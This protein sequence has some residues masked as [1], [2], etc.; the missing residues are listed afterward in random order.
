MKFTKGP[1][2]ID[3]NDSYSIKCSG[4][5]SY[6]LV[7][8]YRAL[9]FVSK[10]SPAKELEANAKLIAASPEMFELLDC[11]EEDIRDGTFDKNNNRESYL[12]SIN[13][14]ITKIE[15]DQS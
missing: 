15:S 8:K 10:N 4:E 9:S 7:T 13:D 12:K 5:V 14:L 6:R 1:W 3:E 11:L 2:A